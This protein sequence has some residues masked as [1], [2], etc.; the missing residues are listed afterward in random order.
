MPNLEQ[1]SV[2]VSQSSRLLGKKL[3]H[4]VN[5]IDRRNKHVQYDSPTDRQPNLT[6]YQILPMHV[7]QR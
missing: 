4:C 3:C 6:K 2:E 5:S 7:F 1:L